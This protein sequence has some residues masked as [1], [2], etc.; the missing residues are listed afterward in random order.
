MTEQTDKCC[1]KCG[2]HGCG[3]TSAAHPLIKIEAVPK[4]MVD[5][6]LREMMGITMLNL[7][8]PAP[9]PKSKKNDLGD[10]FTL[11]IIDDEALSD[12]PNGN[13][14]EPCESRRCSFGYCDQ[15]TINGEAPEQCMDEF[16]RMY[17]LTANA[18][19]SDFG[20]GFERDTGVKGSDTTHSLLLEHARQRSLL[21]ARN[22]DESPATRGGLYEFLQLMQNEYSGQSEPGMRK[23]RHNSMQV[24]EEFDEAIRNL[25]TKAQSS[26]GAVKPNRDEPAK[27]VYESVW[28]VLCGS[29][30]EAKVKKLWS[31]L[32][33]HC[34]DGLDGSINPNE[35]TIDQLFVVAQ[36]EGIVSGELRIN[37]KVV[38]HCG[39]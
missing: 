28:D 9:K 36:Q 32:L 19:H 24:H 39:N 35:A 26:Y 38:F 33:R 37:G 15:A 22:S 25:I 11:V 3:K 17:A 16:A 21:K 12:S 20:N 5:D 4:G 30:E 31:H 29:P 10:T 27:Q 18:P 6:Q 7:T 23:E 2:F 34:V 14:Q 1:K 13:E 8:D